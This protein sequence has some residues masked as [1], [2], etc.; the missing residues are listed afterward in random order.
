VREIKV[1]EEL[2]RPMEGAET[3]ELR[4]ANAEGRTEVWILKAGPILFSGAAAGVGGFI[5]KAYIDGG[6]DI[7]LS[8]QRQ[9]IDRLL[10]HIEAH[11]DELG[12]KA[13]EVCKVTEGNP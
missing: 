11:H 12:I 6:V 10:R 9:S 4:F 7:R 2:G 3:V 13:Q 8:L 1:P 5:W